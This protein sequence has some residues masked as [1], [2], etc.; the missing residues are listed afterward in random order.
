M[1]NLEIAEIK[2]R[3][4]SLINDNYCKEAIELLKQLLIVFPNDLDIYSMYVVAL[5]MLGD[6]EN[7]IAICREG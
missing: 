7:A 5:S 1:D 3:I 2:K 4:E 6:F